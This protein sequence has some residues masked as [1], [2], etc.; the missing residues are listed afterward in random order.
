MPETIG[1]NMEHVLCRLTDTF[2]FRHHPDMA[3]VVQ[4]NDLQCLQE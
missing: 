1:R 3:A 4:E 2:F